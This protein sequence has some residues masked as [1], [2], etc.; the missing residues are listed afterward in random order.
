[1]IIRIIRLEKVT[2]IFRFQFYKLKDYGFG[3]G[4]SPFQNAGCEYD[5]CYVTY[6]KN[7][8]SV[9]EADAIIWHVRGDASLPNVR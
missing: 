9:M 3:I 7:E 1:M 6:D 5:N 4:Q 2:S 8:F